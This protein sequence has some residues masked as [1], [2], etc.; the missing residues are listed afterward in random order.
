MI[1]KFFSSRFFIFFIVT[2]VCIFT[3]TQTTSLRLTS[4]NFG[5]DGGDFLAAILTKGIPHP[6]GY[7]TYTVLGILFQ[8]IPFG[9]EY[10]RVAMLSWLPAALSAGL[11]YLWLLE[12]LRDKP[13]QIASICAILGSLV[14]GFLPFIWSQAII[15]E[16]HGL[17]A[18]FLVLSI[19]WIWL[20]LNH[21]NHKRPVCLLILAFNYGLSLGNHITIFF[22]LPII[23][24]SFIQA[25]K[26]QLPIKTLFLQI[27][28]VILGSSI[29]LYLPL[30]AAHF[31]PINW[32]NP[33]S[34]EGFIWVI[35]GG[36]Y[37]NLLTGVS[38]SQV[39]T[40]ISA[41][42][43]I[44][45]NQFGVIGVIFAVIGVFHYQHKSKI[46]SFGLIYLFFI[47]SIFAILYATD[48]SITYLLSAFLVFTLWIVFALE[49]L[50]TFDH[51]NLPI[52]KILV[53]IYLIFFIAKLPA[54]VREIYP[55]SK[56]QPADYAENALKQIPENAILLTT[57]D[58]DSF[59]LWYYHFGLGWRDDLRIIVLPLTQF[60]W[61]QETLSQ[62]YTDLNYPSFIQQFS[63]N[64]QNWGE[65]IPSL[66]PDRIV[67][68][69]NVDKFEM[70]L[71]LVNCSNNMKFQF[72]IAD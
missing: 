30:R 36:P 34:W 20:L 4:A 52:G 24:A 28:L 67:C 13:K 55:R 68:R 38:P 45:I 1:K 7:P 27:F 3:Y 35:S 72:S 44:L 70:N 12:F 25:R 42:A 50:L 51:R 64:N 57:S 58:P 16:V 11:L 59:P 56:T 19:G 60:R 65:A 61:Y 54:T 6:T 39:F 63:N 15:I 47:S 46:F 22:T 37:Q 8:K 32:G 62:I 26:N 17:Q 43:G 29:Y 31:P 18:L 10:F 23:F 33:Q 48:D 41:L 66:N 14:W 53:V 40:R 5:N 9:D 69:S 21:H 71:I 2:F 49:L